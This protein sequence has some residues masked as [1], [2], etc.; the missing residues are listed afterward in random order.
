MDPH[1][2]F[3]YT[4]MIVLGTIILEHLQLVLFN[5]RGNGLL[6]KVISKSGYHILNI[7]SIEHNK[8]LQ[9][10]RLEIMG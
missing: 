6:W 4:K 2:G 9:A 8:D 5:I 7:M 1:H 3:E 10:P